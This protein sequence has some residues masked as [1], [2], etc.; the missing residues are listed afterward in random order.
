MRPNPCLNLRLNVIDY[1]KKAISGSICVKF[2]ELKNLFTAVIFLILV[3]LCDG[4]CQWVTKVMVLIRRVFRTRVFG[5]RPR[6][7]PRGAPAHQ[8]RHKVAPAP[9][10]LQFKL[11]PAT[12]NT[13][14]WRPLSHRT[15]DAHH[16]NIH[17]CCAPLASCAPF[18]S[19]S[20][21]V[22]R[23]VNAKSDYSL[24]TRHRQ[25]ITSRQDLWSIP[26]G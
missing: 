1:R 23:Y 22:L 20:V 15:A 5:L 6:V 19:R 21:I 11:R 12:A 4:Y 2:S 10:G 3:W 8:R 17:L 14:S 24:H 16:A 13:L 26:P 7:R 9:R 18:L 25:G